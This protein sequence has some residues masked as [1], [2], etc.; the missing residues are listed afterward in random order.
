M[1]LNTVKLLNQPAASSSIADGD[2]HQAILDVGYE[3]WQSPMGRQWSY[4]DMVNHAAV[5]YGEAAKLFILFGK[6]NQ[7]VT[8]GGHF[9]YY[10]NGY[11]S[12]TK[13]G[14]FF[15]SA[16]FDMDM[17]LHKELI[18]LFKEYKL[19]MLPKG[20][21][22]LS[23]LQDLQINLDDDQFITEYCHC[24]DDK[25][26]ECTNGVLEYDNSDYGSVNN[27]SELHRLDTRYYEVAEEFMQNLSTHITGW[28]A[29]NADPIVTSNQRLLFEEV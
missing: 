8:N 11:T 25:D 13:K 6:F 4:A 20:D 29:T 3:A 27:L 5:T 22:V 14:G 12:L 28:F 21:A 9:Q 18:R 10:D 1:S 15:R 17:E 23:I 19:Q 2:Y 26:C 16:R 7:Q 24:R